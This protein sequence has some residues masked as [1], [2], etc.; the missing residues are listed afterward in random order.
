M[1]CDQRDPASENLAYILAVVDWKSITNSYPKLAELE[2]VL[3][4][5]NESG[6]FM[7]SDVNRQRLDTNITKT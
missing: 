7:N 5:T 6:P 2:D 3:K 1:R 4:L